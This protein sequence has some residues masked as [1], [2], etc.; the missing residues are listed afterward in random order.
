MISGAYLLR[1]KKIL[2]V[3]GS[4]ALGSQIIKSR[5]FKN[6]DFPPKKNLNILKRAT[7]SR[8]IKKGYDLVINCAAMARM[9][10][11]EKNPIKA[12]NV[13]SIHLKLYL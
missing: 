1:A 5:S 9:K 8:H 6:L 10:D 12:I 3:G 7:I 2:L 13:Y 4:G 11:C